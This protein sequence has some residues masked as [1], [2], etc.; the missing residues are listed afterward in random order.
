MPDSARR[1]QQRLIGTGQPAYLALAEA[2]ADDIRNGVLQARDRL[3]PLRAVA[4]A[5]HLNYT[6]VA[7]GY[8]E[9]QARG[10]IDSH[11]GRGSFVRAQAAS[12]P[13]R[14]VRSLGLVEMT[15]NLPPEPDDPVLLARM[16][17]GHDQVMAR[18]DLTTLLRYQPFGGD[19]PAREAGARWLA[20]LLPD[21]AAERVL[22][23]PG[24]QSAL[25]AV[26]SLLVRPGEVLCC[27]AITYPGVKAIA[28]QLGVKLQ[29][30]AMDADGIRPD[31]FETA[32]RVHRPKAL[33]LNPTLQ[34]PTTLTVPL[35]RRSELARI[36]L[37]YGIPV[38]EDDAYGLLPSDKVAP[39]ATLAPSLTYYL[40]GMAKHVGAGLRMAYL[41]APDT[42][43]V[44]RLSAVFRA[45]TIMAPPMTV[46]LATQWID[47]GTAHAM[48]R[49]LRAESRRRQALV[50][51]WLPAAQVRTHADAFHLW[52]ELP[53]G[54]NRHLFAM[55]L[56]SI[57]VG[58]VASD[59]FV[60]SGVLPEA[61]RFCL[62]GPMSTQDCGHALEAM[63]ALMLQS[64]DSIA[65]VH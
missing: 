18:H 62:G 60:V 8:A 51:Q 42:S 27:E 26:F 52:L 43:A 53:P 41:V 22:V 49:A 6:T 5:L 17:L 2:I 56:R 55:Q 9:A 4:T 45:T 65:G 64:P 15:M 61:V 10:L 58:V 25:V 16:R 1:W 3:P 12:G 7:R 13:A 24:I 54:W 37:Q 11:P 63:A 21:V 31:A 28:T 47:D 33:Y 34:N 32:C 35:T 39:I 57:G 44:Q 40:T 20:P 48:L 19:A 36:A 30:L 38:I 46:A 50:R 29:G 14:S 59:A 23:C